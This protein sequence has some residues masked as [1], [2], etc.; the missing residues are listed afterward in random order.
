MAGLFTSL[1]FNNGTAHV[2]VSKGQIPNNNS[3]VVEYIEPAASL[4]E[5]S[6][7]TVKHDLKSAAIDRHLLQRTVQLA[8]SDGIVRPITVNFTVTHSKLHTPADVVLQ[9]KMIAACLAD[10]T[11]YNNFVLGLS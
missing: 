2:F 8:C 11:F 1:T 10:T 4:S 6:K 9:Q 7:L 3:I 5:K